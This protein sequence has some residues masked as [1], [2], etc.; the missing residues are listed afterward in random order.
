MSLQR[1]KI[2]TVRLS[3]FIL[4]LALGVGL[5]TCGRAKPNAAARASGRS[6]A[7]A[8]EREK[9]PS[10]TLPAKVDSAPRKIDFATQIRPVLEA[11]CQPCHFAGGKVYEHLPFD[12]PA[13]ITMLGTK[14]FTRIKD[15][16]E[17]RLIAAFLADQSS[18]R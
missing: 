8:S 15:E 16:N 1:N 6:S 17:R 2:G 14:L 5:N 7:S 13:T 4:A 18:G 10:A 9:Q 11:R 3:I 12:R